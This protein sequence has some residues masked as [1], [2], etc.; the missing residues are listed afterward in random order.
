M[1]RT[2]NRM[3]NGMNGM[4]R[5]NGMNGVNN[6]MRGMNNGMR[7]MNNGMNAVRFNPLLQRSP[8]MPLTSPQMV[9]FF[10]LLFH[11]FYFPSHFVV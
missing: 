6:G 9:E 11:A 2:N 3:N 1:G 5:M 8:G 7:G 10:F 4:N